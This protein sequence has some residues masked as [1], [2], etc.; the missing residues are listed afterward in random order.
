MDWSDNPEQAAFRAEVQQ[1]IRDGLPEHY[2]EIA[3]QGGG[4]FE[5]GWQADRKS[6]D[7]TRRGAAEDWS[8]ALAER[9]WVAPHWPKEYGGAGLSSWEQ[10]IYKEELAKAAAPVVG[11]G[12]VSLLGPTLIVHGTDDQKEKYLPGILSGEVAWAQGYSEPGAGSDLAGLQTRASRDGDEFV[13]NG[14]KIWTSG[15][16][17]ADKL[18]ALVRTDPDAPKHRGISFLL[19]DDIKSPGLT[20]RPLISMSWKHIFNETFFE[21][22]RTSANNIVGEE[23]RGWYVGMTLL[24]YERSSVDSAVNDRVSMEHLMA[25]VQTEQGALQSRLD[26]PSVRGD[27]AEAWIATEVAANLSLRVASMQGAGL[28]PNYEASMV[29]M[30]GTETMQR[31]QRTGTRVFGLYAN[32]WDQEGELT[33]M[34][35]R[36]THG[37]VDAIPMTIAGGSS[38][39][40]RNIIATRGLG[41]P[42]S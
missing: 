25:Y 36:F 12:G 28:I 22:V 26:I 38:E 41:L 5:E 42:R 27:L 10:Y 34:R 31:L 35:A 23:N 40:Q 2:Q 18:F 29:K 13:V 15:A 21:D 20:V 17:F 9:G 7:A 8:R 19:F 14:Q 30:F 3:K 33:P 4:M 39:I 11:G 24:D 1:V 37:Y 6:D 16:Q 32:L